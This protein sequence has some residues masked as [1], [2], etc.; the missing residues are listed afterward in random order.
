MLFKSSVCF[1]MRRSNVGAHRLHVVVIMLMR[2][3]SDS[4]RANLSL[5]LLFQL[6]LPCG[7]CLFNF[8]ALHL[9][10]QQ[11]LS[12]MCVVYCVFNAHACGFRQLFN[13]TGLQ[14]SLCV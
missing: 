6:L 8:D 11:N 9:N 5:N 12:T 7:L 10:S 2:M 1:S 13:M 4:S 3:I 14:Y